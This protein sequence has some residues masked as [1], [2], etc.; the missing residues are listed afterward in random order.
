MKNQSILKSY[1]NKRLQEE[2]TPDEATLISIV[3]NPYP[4][5]YVTEI[6][7]DDAVKILKDEYGYDDDK[8]EAIKAEV[9]KNESNIDYAIID[10]HLVDFRVY[11]KDP[12]M[13]DF[14]K[15][16]TT[17]VKDL[18][19]EANKKNIDNAAEHLLLVFDEHDTFRKNDTIPIVKELYNI[20][21]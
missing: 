3:K 8:I 1:Y 19:Y 15:L 10:Q 13:K 12:E 4:G 16:A 20:L 18:G 7:Y 11:N 2:H 21:K 5:K 6:S 9:A 17:I 14:I